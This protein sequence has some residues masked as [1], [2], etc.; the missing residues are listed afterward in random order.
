MNN[1]AP[2]LKAAS[3]TQIPVAPLCRAVA[4]GALQCGSARPLAKTTPPDAGGPEYADPYV[5]VTLAG[6]TLRQTAPRRLL[7]LVALVVDLPESVS[8]EDVSYAQSA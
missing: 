3:E 5:Q 1:A 6:V 4:A 8:A 7:M 2:A